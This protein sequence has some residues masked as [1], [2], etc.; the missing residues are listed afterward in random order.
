M[1]YILYNF[2][3]FNALKICFN[4][5]DC[6]L[7]IPKKSALKKRRKHFIKRLSFVSDQENECGLTGS[8]VISS[9]GFKHNLRYFGYALADG[10]PVV[11]YPGRTTI[12]VQET[13]NRELRRVDSKLTELLTKVIFAGLNSY[14]NIDS[15]SVTH[16][17][18][19][20]PI[21]LCYH[22]LIIRYLKMF[23]QLRE[24]S[25]RFGFFRFKQQKR[26]FK[27][28]SSIK[29]NL[30]KQQ[31]KKLKKNDYKLITF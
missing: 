21:V 16:F 1:T 2:Y 3:D 26:V 24:R 15:P 13:K 30:L 4:N 23:F 20:N 25:L 9:I 5:D 8:L 27:K 17:L 31:K 7:I 18:S 22:K 6:G 12:F 11:Y 14:K 28:F 10:K 19:F 29:K